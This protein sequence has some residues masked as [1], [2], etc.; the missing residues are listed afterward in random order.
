[1]LINFLPVD[2]TGVLTDPVSSLSSAQLSEGSGDFASVRRGSLPDSV[3]GGRSVGH[4]S[5]S[6]QESMDPEGRT[7]E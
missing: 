4:D 3:S 1:M 7:V 5:V 6:V 2:E